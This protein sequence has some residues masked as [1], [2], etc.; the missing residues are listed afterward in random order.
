MT[1]PPQA[2]KVFTDPLLVFGRYVTVRN[3][4]TTED[5]GE[6]V[7]VYQNLNGLMELVQAN[8]TLNDYTFVPERQEWAIT[9]R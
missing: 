1:T 6:I 3:I 2:A 8:P 9:K 4:E 5:E 7:P